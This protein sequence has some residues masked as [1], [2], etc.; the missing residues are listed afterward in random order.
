LSNR[1]DSLLGIVD[2]AGSGII[3]VSSLLGSERRKDIS[4]DLELVK[5][6]RS[7]R[8]GCK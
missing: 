3:S 1:L 5:L 2:N 8:R 6:G 7:K 4:L